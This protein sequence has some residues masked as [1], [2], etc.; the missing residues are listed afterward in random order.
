MG[1]ILVNK[2]RENIVL[3]SLFS[4]IIIVLM[5]LIILSGNSPLLAC[6]IIFENFSNIGNIG[7]IFVEVIVL[8]LT[9]LSFTFALQA[10]L[11]NI[12]S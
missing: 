9:G 10:N 2:L 7:E 4:L 1:K 5:L 3:I 8:S 12:G 6:K 11:F